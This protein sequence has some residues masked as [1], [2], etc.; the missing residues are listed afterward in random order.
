MTKRLSIPKLYA[1][2]LLILRVRST[3]LGRSRKRSSHLFRLFRPRRPTGNPRERT[4]RWNCFRICI[5]TIDPRVVPRTKWSFR[6]PAPTRIRK[7]IGRDRLVLRFSRASR[8]Q[9]KRNVAATIA[10]ASP[11]DCAIAPAPRVPS[12]ASICKRVASP[13]QV[14]WLLVAAFPRKELL[15]KRKSDWRRSFP[16]TTKTWQWA[17]EF[18]EI[19]N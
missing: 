6:R 9:L 18:F 16:S 13:V 19:Q 2:Q 3:C 12:I 17:P 14:R 5:R 10:L 1:I 4:P 8:R 11:T 15:P 7:S